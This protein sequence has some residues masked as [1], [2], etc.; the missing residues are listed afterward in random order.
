M[1]TVFAYATLLLFALFGSPSTG[2]A[3]MPMGQ[4]GRDMQP[5]FGGSL[6]VCY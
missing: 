4:M 1:K 6:A 3:Q 5:L 2:R